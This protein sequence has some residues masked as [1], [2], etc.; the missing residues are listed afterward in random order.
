M[1]GEIEI[2]DQPTIRHLPQIRPLYAIQQVTPA[3]I[4]LLAAGRI[5][6]RQEHAT[7]IAGNPENGQFPTQRTLQSYRPAKRAGDDRAILPRIQGDGITV[8][9]NKPDRET[10]RRVI[11]KA[12]NTIHDPTVPRFQW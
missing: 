4:G 9:R 10:H 3:A 6:K 7:A 12:G 5:L 11:V 1:I 2:Q 8:I